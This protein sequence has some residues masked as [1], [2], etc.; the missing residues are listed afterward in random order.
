[1]AGI[2]TA[3]VIG[4]LTQ[5]LRDA[6]PNHDARSWRVGSV[7]C[8]RDRHR[9]SGQSYTFGIEVLQA[10]FVQHGHPSWRLAIV[11]ER[12]WAG[13]SDLLIRDSTWLKLV[14][15]KAADVTG[16]IKQ[17]QRR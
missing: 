1:M 6:S 8:T 5:I 14:A 15:G 10:H 17:A 16:W 13:D 9:H 11:S 12:W 2:A 7:A 4:Q 3:R